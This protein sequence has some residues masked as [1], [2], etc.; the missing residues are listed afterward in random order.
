M[1]APPEVCALNGL[2]VSINRL[3]V[4]AERLWDSSEYER[5]GTDRARRLAYVA[6]LCVRDT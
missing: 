6:E 1:L 3:L 4:S 2:V 5:G